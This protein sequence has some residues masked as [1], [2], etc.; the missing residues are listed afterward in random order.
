MNTAAGL[1]ELT[2]EMLWWHFVVFL[3]VAPVIALFPGFGE[4]T[5]PARIKLAL[6]LALTVAV[7]PILLP[8]LGPARPGANGLAWLVVTQTGVGLLLGVG[9]RLFVL[10]L[11]TTGTI[12]AQATSLSQ[13]LGTAGVEPIPAMGHLL[14]VG[15]LALA[16]MAGLHVRAAE[17]LVLSYRLFPLA[18]L[19]APQAVSEWGIRQVAGA[20]GLAFTLA[21]P[22]VLV[23]VLY[24][25]TLGIIN[26]A[27]PQLM[28]VFVGAPVITGLGLVVLLVMAPTLLALWVDALGRFMINPFGGR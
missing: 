23:S 2:R 22:F 24:N 19:P 17:T 28:V 5:V 21:A 8:D 25:L 11:Q 4:T 3:R 18:E 7:T 14:V 1:L 6:A 10:A 27:M 9:V 12:A 16:M 13:I 20:F 26:R 15:G